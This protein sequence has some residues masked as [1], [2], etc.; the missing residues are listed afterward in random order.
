MDTAEQLVLQHI[1]SSMETYQASDLHLSVGNPPMMRVRG[2]LVAMPDQPVLTPSFIETVASTW[3]DPYYLGVLKEKKDVVCARSFENKR[4]F[5]IAAYY[6]QGHIALTLS[7]VPVVIPPLQQIGLPPLAQRLALLD[8]GLVCIIGPLDTQN[9]LTAASFIEYFNQT[10]QRHVV[11]I[12][13]PIEYVFQ[14]NQSVIEQREVGVDVPSTEAALDAAFHE[15]VDVVMVSAIPS[16]RAWRSVVTLANM[17]KLVFVISHANSIVSLLQSIGRD[18]EGI[19]QDHIRLE[20]AGALAGVINQRIVSTTNGELMP[21][22]ELV[23]PNDAVRT[24]I[25][26]GDFV[27]MQN[28]LA[29]SRDEG[30]RSLDMSLRMAVDAGRITRQEAAKHAENPRLFM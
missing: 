22:V 14:D 8:R 2:R 16:T 10:T 29:T 28:I 20:F 9:V 19:E 3:L 7:P 18:A 26:S 27:Q 30:M 23:I 5:K 12:E 15:D 1:L 6:Q 17:G 13:Q 4:R 11:T 21:I 24:V 25:Q